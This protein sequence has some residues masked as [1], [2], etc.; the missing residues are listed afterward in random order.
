MNLIT[1]L[2]RYF[3]GADTPTRNEKP[4][5]DQTSYHQLLLSLQ[6]ACA[7][8]PE[9]EAF[10]TLDKGEFS[11]RDVEPR[12]QQGARTP[13]V[14]PERQWGSHPMDGGEAGRRG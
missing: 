13:D 2:K 4:A 14:Q 6:Q 5:Q 7:H 12:T 8:M 11:V 1:N 9:G 10:I 3:W